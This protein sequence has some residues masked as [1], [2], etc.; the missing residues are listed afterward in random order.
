MEHNKISNFMNMTLS[1]KLIKFI[2]DFMYLTLE[3]IGVLWEIVVSTI[4]FSMNNKIFMVSLVISLIIVSP[5]SKEILN[6]FL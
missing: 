6:S 5:E 3:L 2:H 4:R 1:N